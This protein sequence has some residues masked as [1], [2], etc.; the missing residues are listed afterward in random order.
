MGMII[1]KIFKYSHAGIIHK[2]FFQF[3]FQQPNMIPDF[4]ISIVSGSMTNILSF[5]E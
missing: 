5:M 3:L 1:N 2:I 4:F